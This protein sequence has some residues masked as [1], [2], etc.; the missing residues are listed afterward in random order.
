MRKLFRLFAL[1][2]LPVLVVG[3]VAPQQ[4][5]RICCGWPCPPTV[6]GPP[7]TLK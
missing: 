4:L 5:A 1:A 3:T 7:V 6:C 2:V